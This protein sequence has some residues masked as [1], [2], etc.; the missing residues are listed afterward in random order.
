MGF[1][2]LDYYIVAGYLLLIA[3][4]GVVAGGKQRDTSDYFLGHGKIPWLAVCFAIVATETSTLTFISIP[5]LAYVTNLNFLQVTFGYLVGRIIISVILLPAYSRGDL[6]T[7]YQLLGDRFGPGMRKLS[8]VVFMIT[9]VFADGVRLFAT[10]I[11]L[12]L[13]LAGWNQFS[14]VPTEQVYVVAIVILAVITLAYTYAG[15]VRAV[16]WTDVIQMF[17]YLGGAVGA[18]IVLLSGLPSGGLPAD[19]LSIIRSGFDLSLSEFFAAPYTLPAGIL[20]GAFLSMASHGTD[21]IIVQRLLTIRSLEGSRKALIGSGVIIILQFALFLVLGVLLYQFYGG[22]SLQEIGLTNADEIFPKFIVEQIPSGLSGLIVAGLLAAA[23][24]TLSGSVNSL[25]SA[26]VHDL[27]LPFAKQRRSTIS[28]LTISR[29]ASLLWCA[30]LVG[31]A[32]FF[33]SYRTGFLVELALSIASV[34]YGG[35][36]GVFLLGILARS[37][38]EVD[39]IVGF[40]V[41]IGIMALVFTGSNLAWTWY[42]PLG[43]SISFGVGWLTARLRT[44]SA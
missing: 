23:M 43:T 9:R 4:V 28:D 37:V 7:A 25:A 26:T 22:A 36:L 16:I 6:V 21:H 30:L 15:G 8:S 27:Y 3:V 14:D 19:K 31:V 18:A 1:N 29:I 38:G 11:P 10:A 39:A 41:G 20:G 42:V 5:G 13:L 40:L 12:A 34:T 2:T 35:L 17:I 33:I 44:R 32:I 24:S